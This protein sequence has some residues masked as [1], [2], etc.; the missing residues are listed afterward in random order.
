MRL[1]QI[2]AAVGLVVA[3]ASCPADIARGE[4]E[5]IGIGGGGAIFTPVV[6]PGDSKVMFVTCD[7]GGVYKTTDGGKWQVFDKFPFRGVT[8]IEF[9]PAD[10]KVLYACTYGVSALKGNYLP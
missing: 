10:H 7:M 5:V 9:D 6:Y 1:A 3:S 4:W 8:A 2:L